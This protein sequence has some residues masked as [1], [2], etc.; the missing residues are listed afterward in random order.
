MPVSAA[1]WAAPDRGARSFGAPEVV[2]EAYAVEMV[3]RGA[4][5]DVGRKGLVGE[6]PGHDRQSAAGSDE[7]DL[8]LHHGFSTGV[9][10]RR[11]AGP[12][13]D[14]AAVAFGGVV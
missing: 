8:G 4:A 7:I 12:G 11:P 9:A 13:G 1:S 5:G 10:T 6:G 2:G 14:G 3:C